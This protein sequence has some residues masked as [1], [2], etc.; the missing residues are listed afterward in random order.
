MSCHLF[1]VVKKNYFCVVFLI[2][3]IQLISFVSSIEFTYPINP[4]QKKCIGEY[5]RE[6]TVGK[7][8]LIKK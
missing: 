5:L 6:S 4:N 3:Y 8:K 1:S 7:S 2:I